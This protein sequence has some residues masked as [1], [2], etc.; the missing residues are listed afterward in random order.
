MSG[1]G[2]NATSEDQM[3]WLLANDNVTAFAAAHRFFAAFLAIAFLR[4]GVSA[5][6]RA[7]PPFFPR[8]DACGFF[9]FVMAS[10]Y[11][12]P[13]VKHLYRKLTLFLCLASGIKCTDVEM[14]I[15]LD[16]MLTDKHTCMA[17]RNH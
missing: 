3:R 1:A 9:S 7:A 13:G 5:F 12:M 8:A 17:G 11:T 4:C 2:A 16:T 14:H 15:S 10:V 6:A